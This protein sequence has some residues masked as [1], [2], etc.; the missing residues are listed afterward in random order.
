MQ[1]V[2]IDKTG[3]GMD[4]EFKTKLTSI[5]GQLDP[6]ARKIGMEDIESVLQAGGDSCE[7]LTELL[8]RKETPKEIREKACWLIGR[9]G[10]KGAMP[11]LVDTL[12]DEDAGLRAEAAR[13]L[14][15]FGDDRAVP[16]L[17][18]ALLRDNDNYVRMYTAYSLGLLGTSEGS[19]ALMKALENENE[20]PGV[21][22]MAAESLGNLRYKD[23]A[24]LLIEG[25]RDKT[26]EV[27]F[28]CI[29]ALGEMGEVRALAQLE[30]LAKTDPESLE[31]W[32]SIREEA[33]AAIRLIKDTGQ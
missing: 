31:G 33:L 22:G 4:K 30:R 6:D 19:K 27:R 5:I 12:A 16:H 15:T 9:L 18:S 21:R 8:K 13:S 32:G 14:G 29:F 20:D 1:K 3:T 24:D 10:D 23:A 26:V 17:I 11:L 28:W 7:N 2:L 25:L